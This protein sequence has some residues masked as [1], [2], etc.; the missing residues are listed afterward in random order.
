[1]IVAITASTKIIDGHP[2]V[3]LNE[4]YVTAIAGAGLVPLVV[5]PLE[6]LDPD[7]VLDAV[8]GL[9]L[10]GGEDVDPAEYGATASP[11]TYAPHP[12]RDATELALARRARE[13]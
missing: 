3:R 11:R 2:R 12:R 8:Q 10:S 6:Q 4:A 7:A 9:V 1:M 5:P 13:R